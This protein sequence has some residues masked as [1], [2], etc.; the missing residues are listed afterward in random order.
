MDVEVLC[1]L[2]SCQLKGTNRH[3][4]IFRGT[5]LLLCLWICYV[6]FL[7]AIGNGYKD[8]KAA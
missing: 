6:P 3:F 4:G 5:I 2:L 1:L 7:L 8:S